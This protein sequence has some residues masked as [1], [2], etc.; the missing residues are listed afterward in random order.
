MNFPSDFKYVLGLQEEY[1][2]GMADG[3][4]QAS[5]KPTV[6]VVHSAAGMAN[7]MGNIVTAFLNKSPLILIA[8]NQ[9]REML[10]GD[11]TSPTVILRCCHS[12]G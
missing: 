6:A 5:R 11:H 7:A 3:Y 10:V 8:G 1:V 12:H 4:A 9:A 2:V